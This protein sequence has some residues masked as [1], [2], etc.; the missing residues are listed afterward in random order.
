MLIGTLAAF[1]HGSA[2][3]VAMVIFGD[4]TDAFIDHA[5][6]ITLYP[7]IQC[8]AEGTVSNLT[9]ISSAPTNCSDLY[10]LSTQN[11]T[12][13][14]YENVLESLVGQ[15]VRCLPN[16]SFISVMNNLVY[17]FLGIAVLAFLFGVIQM[18]C[19]KVPSERQIHKLRLTLYGSIVRKD[20]GWFDV[21]DSGTISSHLTR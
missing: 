12:C 14:S 19:F 2:F 21:S 20:M 11:L 1:L 5:R 10:A 15:M 17:I 13:L 3:P 7:L 6:T 18:W 4:I 8:S 9:M 16:D